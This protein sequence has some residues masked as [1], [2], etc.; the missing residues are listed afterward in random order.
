[1]LQPVP[2]TEGVG[3]QDRGRRDM[4]LPENHSKEA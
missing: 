1:M 2:G 4:I 3:Q